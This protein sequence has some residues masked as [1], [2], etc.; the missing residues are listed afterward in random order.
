MVLPSIQCT[1]MFINCSECSQ[2][3]F[4][5]GCLAQFPMQWWFIVKIYRDCDSP[6]SSGISI[7]T[8]L[9]SNLPPKFSNRNHLSIDTCVWR[10]ETMLSQIY[11]PNRHAFI[12]SYMSSCHLLHQKTSIHYSQALRLHKICMKDSDSV[13]HTN[14]LTQHLWH[15]YS[16]E[17]MHTTN[18]NSIQQRTECLKNPNTHT[19]KHSIG[20]PLPP[21]QLSLRSTTST[22][23]NN[24]FCTSFRNKYLPS[25]LQQAKK[26]S[27]TYW[28]KDGYI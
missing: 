14:H 23:T 17:H 6:P 19:H 21:M 11:T 25:Q 28:Y 3:E 18:T 24:K 27:E 9:Q 22:T 20:H 13:K 4:I 5:D 1:S 16:I 2:I 10:E 12:S 26:I 8:M 7:N 15:G